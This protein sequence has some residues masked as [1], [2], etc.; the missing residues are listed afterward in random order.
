[1]GYVIGFSSGMFYTADAGEKESF[2][3]A[4]R[5]MF[6]GA[7]EGVTFTQV[8]MESITEL[9]EPYAKEGIRRMK[10]LG[11]RLGF[12][13]ES[14]AMGGSEKPIG[15]L[16]SCLETEYNHAHI[17]LIEHIR[18]CGEVGGEFVNVHPSETPAFIKL[19]NHLQPTKLVD[20]WGRPFKEFLG[21]KKNEELLE[22]AVDAVDN[23]IITI[24]HLRNY[25][26]ENI[27]ELRNKIPEGKKLTSEE[28]KAMKREAI[29]ESIL[30]VVYSNDL[31]YGAEAIAYTIIAKWMQ[32]NDDPLWKNIVNKDIPDNKLMDIDEVKVWVPA[33]SAKYMLGHFRPIKGSRFEDPIPL[34][35]NARGKDL[36]MYFVFETQMGGSGL[37]GYQRLSHPRDMIFLCKE[38]GSKWVA[39]CF[40]F[41]HVLSQDIDPEDEIKSIP[42]GMGKYVKV[43]HLGWPTP[44]IP[45]H[46][47]I[48]LGSEGQEYL[49]KRLYEL[50]Q[51][52]MMDAYFIFERAG[53]GRETTI[54]ALRM[55][56]RYLEQNRDPSKLDLEFYGMDDK[57][58]DVKRQ[59]V[60][61]R[62]HFF[63]PM[64]GMLNVPEEEYTFL[65]KAATEKGKSEIWKKE[66][67]R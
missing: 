6:R 64:K 11:L 25:Y 48:P 4:P 42:D 51:K 23:D 47:P 9:R 33:V 62:D 40:D 35:E 8:D 45:A 65:S 14:Y 12:H 21:E 26:I 37:E 58:P 39:V 7:L 19:G 10:S 52:G 17:R 3:T 59:Q 43:C 63:D 20:P 67:Y 46:M 60:V 36:G 27:N 34:L 66:Q 5:K 2:L 16:D 57:T 31:E 54:L 55:I 28:E 38:I 32:K 18:R 56:K 22:W 44:H 1:M 50:R 41:E 30:D 29:K 24:T 13:G 61:V 53:A 49:Y 15:M